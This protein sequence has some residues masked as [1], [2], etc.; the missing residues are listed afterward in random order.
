MG[1]KRPTR[2]LEHRL[3]IGLVHKGKPKSLEANQKN[4]ISNIKSHF[5]EMKPIERID[6]ITGE[7]KEYSGIGEAKRDGFRR[8]EISKCCNGKQK[9]HMRF[10]WRFL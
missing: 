4:S 3:K 1:F 5:H 8:Q 10:Y 9:S 2:S 7:I 6:R